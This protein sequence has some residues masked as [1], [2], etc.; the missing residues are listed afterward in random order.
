[1]TFS[2]TLSMIIQISNYKNIISFNNYS[3]L[4]SWPHKQIIKEI[5]KQSPYHISTLAI[6]PDT[7]EINTFNL[8]A[9]YITLF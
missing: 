2:I 1:M 9:E 8:E 3:F 5:E 7:I 4:K 6:L